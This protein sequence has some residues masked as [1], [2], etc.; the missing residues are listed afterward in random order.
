[1]YK[2]NIDLALLDDLKVVFV[3]ILEGP[4]RVEL[5]AAIGFRLSAFDTAPVKAILE[6]MLEKLVRH[7]LLDTGTPQLSTYTLNSAEVLLEDL[8]S[9]KE[10]DYAISESNN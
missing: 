8:N 2:E 3:N 1:L 5:A 6:F 10:L 9:I 7:I 4:R